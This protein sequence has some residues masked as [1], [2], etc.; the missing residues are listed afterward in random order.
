MDKRSLRACALPAAALALSLLA[1]CLPSGQRDDAPSGAPKD[2]A[3]PASPRPVASEA[4]GRGAAPGAPASPPPLPEM[5]RAEAGAFV[6]GSED[7]AADE[8]PAHRVRIARDLL[9]AVRKVTAEEYDRF[10]DETGRARPKSRLGFDGS[11]LPAIDVDWYD[12]VAYCD[13]LSRLHGLA[14]CYSGEGLKTACDFG[15]SG[16]RLPT[17][18]EWEWAA[19]GGRLSKG[20]RWAGSDDPLA[21]AW[22]GENS[23]G[24]MR[25]VG[26]LKPNELG[27]CDMSGNLYEWCW[28]FYGRDYYASSPETDPEGPPPGRPATPRGPEHSRR[29]GSWREGRESVR[30]AFRSLDNAGYPGD[31]GFR[32]FRTAPSE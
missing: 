23:Q 10:C 28:D 26:L 14:P 25:D 22:F 31:N 4:S 21:V 8:R 16:Y 12:A 17:E 11:R 29:A 15:A 20:F 27:L 32:L 2:T 24:A 18:A 7:G 6:M 19:R 30:V 5:V 1:A 9:V 3:A 13:W